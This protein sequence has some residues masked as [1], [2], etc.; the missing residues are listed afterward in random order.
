MA[1]TARSGSALGRPAERGEGPS[2]ADQ[3]DDLLPRHP[4]RLVASGGVRVA[5][6]RRLVIPFGLGDRRAGGGEGVPVDRQQR[7]EAFASDAANAGA[8]A[9]IAV[10][11]VVGRLI[12]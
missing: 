10:R 4:E 12:A 2:M 5:V 1:A 6:A 7:L 9:A 11:T 3:R 8:P